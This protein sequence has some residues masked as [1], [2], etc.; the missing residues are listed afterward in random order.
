MNG[1]GSVIK[2]FLSR[3]HVVF[4][5]FCNARARHSEAMQL[6]RMMWSSLRLAMQIK[7]DENYK[8][9]RCFFDC[10]KPVSSSEMVT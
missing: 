6:I 8:F 9:Y 5:K 4:S 1:H 2:R 7:L 3:A 10:R